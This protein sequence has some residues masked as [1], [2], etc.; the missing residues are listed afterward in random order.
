MMKSTALVVLAIWLVS[1]N[2]VGQ[3][4][5]QGQWVLNFEK[6]LESMSSGMRLKYDTLPSSIKARA[7]ESMLYRTFSLN[8]NGALSVK[9]NVRNTERYSNG[10]WTLDEQ[11]TKLVFHID[12]AVFEYS[13][14]QPNADALV[15]IS[16][17]DDGY[18]NSLYLERLSH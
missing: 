11:G 7:K 3:A 12:N 6:S 15:L 10:T 8:E 9:M 18:F 2:A 1:F 14:E 17:R 13:I 4:N 16:D 5:F